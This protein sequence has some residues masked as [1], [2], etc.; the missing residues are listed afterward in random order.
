MHWHLW[1]HYIRGYTCNYLIGGGKRYNAVT[2]V[3]LCLRLH[4]ASMSESSHVL[5]CFPELSDVYTLLLFSSEL[6]D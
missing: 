5:L 1:D 3:G 4:P 6:T 2:A